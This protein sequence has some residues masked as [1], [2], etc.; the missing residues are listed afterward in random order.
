MDLSQ[1]CQ[2]LLS[3]FAI[4]LNAVFYKEEEEALTP[5]NARLNG[6]TSHVNGDG[7]VKLLNGG[8]GKHNALYNG[9]HHPT[10]NISG[11]GVVLGFGIKLVGKN[12]SNFS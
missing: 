7:G 11:W 12:V 9:H 8:S 2:S 6:L 5:T 1:W 10:V 3:Q 4:V